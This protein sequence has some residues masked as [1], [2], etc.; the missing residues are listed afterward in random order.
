MHSLVVDYSNAVRPSSKT[1]YLEHMTADAS[2]SAKDMGRRH[3]TAA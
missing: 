3:D 1:H 2:G